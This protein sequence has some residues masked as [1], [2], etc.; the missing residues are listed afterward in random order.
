M[1]RPGVVVS[2]RADAPPRSAPTD[3]GM[4][5]MVGA[6]EK[7]ANIKTVSSMNQYTTEFGIRAG[8]TDTYDA[9]DTFFREGGASLT[10]VKTSGAAQ[11]GIDA[12]LAGLTKAWGPGQ[13]FIASPTLAEAPAGQS[14]LIAHAKANNRIALLEAAPAST[15]AQLGTLAATLRSN[16]DARYAALFAPGVVVPGVT[17]GTTRVVPASALVAGVISRNDRTYSPNVAA[18]GVN[19]EARF[20]TDV[21][22][23]YTDAERDTLNIAG[24]SIVRTMY[25]GV[26]V[27]GYRTPADPNTG[28]HL[29]SN[30]RLN[31]A[32]VA[33]AEAI[34]ENF[35][36]SQIDG[37]RVKISQFGAELTGMLVPYYEAGSLFGESPD[38][39]FY[40]DVGP[41]VNTL[42]TIAAGELHAIIGLRMS[43]FAEYV[44]IEIVKVATET[45]LSVAA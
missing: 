1:A 22:L 6:T 30:A 32:I 17:S 29:L 28:W 23:P 34:G 5:F 31:M 36:F 24:V 9:A 19:G 13:I 44:V 11:A 14:S 21:S 33:K 40:V 3:T 20:A 43:P 8:Y 42:A 45:P 7:G 10:V 35:L 26:R 38:D 39:A 2:S 37:R 27:Y 4:A 41:A 12:A 18:A 15:A 16:Q 25:G